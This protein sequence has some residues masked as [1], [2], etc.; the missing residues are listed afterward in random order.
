MLT[1][2]V[3]NFQR[4]QLPHIA[5]SRPHWTN[6]IYSAHPIQIIQM[7]TLTKSLALCSPT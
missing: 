3:I 1:G 4:T 2:T 5:V 7:E 6:Y